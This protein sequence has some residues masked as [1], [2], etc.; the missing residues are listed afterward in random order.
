MY[1]IYAHARFVHVDLDARSQ[2]IGKD[3]I[4]A[5]HALGNQESNRLSTTVRHLLHD[6]DFAKRV[7]G[8]TIFLMC[9]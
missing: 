8:L 5:L 6:L 4:M 1:A 2:W 9:T 3:K 7:Y